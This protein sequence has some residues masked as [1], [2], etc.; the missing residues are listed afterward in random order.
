MADSAYE[1]VLRNAKT[2]PVTVTVREPVP[3]DW[4][5]LEES[6]R[7]TKVAAGT[8]EWRVEVPAGGSTTL[9]YRVQVRF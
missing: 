2:E 7:H 9:K 5:M 8:A 4:T 3:G 1:I 6:Q